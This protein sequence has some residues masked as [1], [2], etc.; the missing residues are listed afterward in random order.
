MKT[1][2]EEGAKIKRLWEPRSNAYT[3]SAAPPSIATLHDRRG[4]SKSVRARTK[5]SAVCLFKITVNKARTMTISIDVLS[6]EKKI[7]WGSPSRQKAA[8]N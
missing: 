6:Q 8:D 7:S 2:H 4:G 3:L 1:T 5:K